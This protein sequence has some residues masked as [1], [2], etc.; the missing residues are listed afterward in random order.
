MKKKIF[1]YAWHIPHQY[2]LFN[3]LHDCEFYLLN[4]NRVRP[5]WNKKQRPLPKNIRFV[6]KYEQG[7]Y[8]FAI[9]HMDELVESNQNW[10]QIYRQMNSQIRDIPK[11]VIMHGI[12]RNDRNLE[13]MKQLVG[14][15]YVAHNA[16]QTYEI[17]GKQEKH[18]TIWHGYDIDEFK[19]TDYSRDNIVVVCSRHEWS[20]PVSGFDFACQ[21]GAKYK[22]DWLGWTKNCDT[23]QQYRNFLAKSSIYLSPHIASPMPG[24]RTEA[25]LSG[26]CVLTTNYLIDEDYLKDGENCYIVKTPDDVDTILKYLKLNKDKIKQIGQ[27]GRKT[28]Q[29]LFNIKRYRNDWLNFINEIL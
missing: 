21:V 10:G 4:D 11:V 15:N 29:E 6:D 22:L 8:D 14:D 7:R 27:A 9:L 5:N 2:R 25:M 17:F 12:P 24:A 23:Y 19:Q 13:R 3:A 20:R 16:K 28:A 26:L 18:R 1:N